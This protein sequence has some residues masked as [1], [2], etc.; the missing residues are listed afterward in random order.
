MTRRNVQS[1]VIASTDAPWGE[2]MNRRFRLA[3]FKAFLEVEDPSAIDRV[4]EIA[5]R[6]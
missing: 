6:L 2:F 1:V 3:Y 5:A 4:G